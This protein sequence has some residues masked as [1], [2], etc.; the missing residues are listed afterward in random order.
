MSKNTELNNAGSAK[1][2]EFYT[3]YDDI[4]KEDYSMFSVDS[5]NIYERILKNNIN[6][7]TIEKIN[8]S[9]YVVDTLE[10]SLW[11]LLKTH[12]YKDSILNA[13]NLGGDADTVAAVTGS[14][15]GIIYGYDSFPKDW[16]DNLAR[17]EYIE[18][19]CNKFEKKLEN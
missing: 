8:S 3:D 15:S 12:N 6:E 11:V 13:V 9:V 16:I 10:A 14:M 18:D 1:K 2:D 4:K 17:K 5:L 7:L 19:L